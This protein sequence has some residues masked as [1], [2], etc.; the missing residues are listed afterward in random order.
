MTPCGCG[1]KA[2]AT[3]TKAALRPAAKPVAASANGA[4]FGRVRHRAE[5][6]AII[7]SGP[8]LAGVDLTPLQGVTTIAVNGAIEGMPFAPTFWFTMDASERNRAIMRDQ[9]P[10]TT[11]YAAVYDVYGTA[12]AAHR[13]M[14]PAPEPDVIYLRRIHGNGPVASKEGLSTDPTGVHAGNRGYGALGLATL[15]QAKRGAL[16]G[17]DCSGGYGSGAGKPDALVQLPWLFGTAWAQLAEAGLAV[18]NGSPRSKVK[19]WDRMTPEEAMA[20]LVAE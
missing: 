13:H 6:I 4:I 15:L 11:Y 7:A 12:K 14:R 5:R 1:G 2:K 18:V 10:G 20:W 17:G 8:S 16:F 3:A 19:A 9:R